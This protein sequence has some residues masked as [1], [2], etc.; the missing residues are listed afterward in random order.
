MVISLD[1]G[2]FA[3]IGTNALINSIG[4]RVPTGIGPGSI[5]F[6]STIAA[7]PNCRNRSPPA[8]ADLSNGIAARA[9]K[10]PQKFTAT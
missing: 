2:D 8:R 5:E 6:H 4:D 9:E 7:T 3:A 10:L 1:I